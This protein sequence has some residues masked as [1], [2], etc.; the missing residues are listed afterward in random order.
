MNN[1]II[2]KIINM[3]K[4]SAK[5]VRKKIKEI[6][7]YRNNNKILFT[8]EKIKV[9][10]FIKSNFIKS[11]DNNKI[12]KVLFTSQYQKVQKSGLFL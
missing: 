12:N 3:L 5:L 1:I 11:L 6:L 8:F 4:K 2:L 7:I 9:I 10:Y